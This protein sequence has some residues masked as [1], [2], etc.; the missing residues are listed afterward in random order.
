MAKKPIKLN[1]KPE[2]MDKSGKMSKYP[3]PKKGK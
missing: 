2:F 3:K 1:K